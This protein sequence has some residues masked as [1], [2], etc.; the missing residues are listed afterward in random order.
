M[1]G[2]L[3]RTQPGKKGITH[4]P[5]TISKLT[6]EPIVL[7]QLDLANHEDA[8]RTSLQIQLAHIASSLSPLVMVLDLR[9]QDIRFCDVLLFIADCETEPRG[10]AADP[11]IDTIFLSSHPMLPVL[12]QRFIQ[13]FKLPV[14]CARTMDD[15]LHMARVSLD[16]AARKIVNDS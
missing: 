7:V 13:R 10:T 14:R 8:S 3:A 2:E 4:M 9:G 15:A 1:I 5:F 6:Q 11:R 12:Q 16:A